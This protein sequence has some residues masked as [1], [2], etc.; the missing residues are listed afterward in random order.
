MDLGHPLDLGVSVG[1]ADAVASARAAEDLGLD[2]VVVG[3]DDLDAW[4]VLGWVAGG[5]ERV[6]VAA[7][8]LTLDGRPPAVLARAVASLDH[9]SGGRVA[10]GLAPDPDLPE[11]VAVLRGMW[12]AGEPGPLVH[13]GPR[14]RVPGA[15]R[16]P[17]PAHEVAVWSGPAVGSGAEAAQVRALAARDADGWWCD[18]ADV[19]AAG[20][21]REVVA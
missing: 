15:Q 14:Y 3:D 21:L 20:A 5:T 11:A 12:A 8:G 4:T 2:L 13:D 7:R 17:A 16:G 1:G 9:L 19:S 6:A 18:A 10:L